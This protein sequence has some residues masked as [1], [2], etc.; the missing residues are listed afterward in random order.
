[1]QQLETLK[2]SEL[3]DENL[4]FFCLYALKIYNNPLFHRINNELNLSKNVESFFYVL[5]KDVLLN[6]IF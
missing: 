1:M 2:G 5:Q 6:F 3:Y 4:L